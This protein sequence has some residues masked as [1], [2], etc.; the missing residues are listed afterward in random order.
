LIVPLDGNP[1]TNCQELRDILYLFKKTRTVGYSDNQDIPSSWQP[2]IVDEGIGA[3]VH[4]IGTVL[5]SGGVNVDFLL[6]ADFSG[7]ML[8]DGAYT[9]P[10]LSWKIRNYWFG[11]DRTQFRKLELINDSIG[12]HLYC[13]LPNGNLLIGN[14]QNGMNTKDIRWSKWTFDIPITTLELINTTTILLGATVNGVSQ[15]GLYKIVTG[16]TNVTTTVKIPNPLVK[17][18][19]TD[20]GEGENIHHFAGIRLRVKGSGN[21][22]PTVFSL[23][24]VLSEVL[25]PIPMLSTTERQLTRLCNLQTQRAALELKTTELNEIF[26]IG[27]IIFYAKEVFTEFPSVQ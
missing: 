9:R 5:D 15:S 13:V 21:L 26:N 10:E 7:I 16:K 25:V 18:A 23:D 11:L 12:E 20:L 22:K 27:R 8:F 17:T 6:V 4:G 19:Y 3:P 1:L 2:F 24:D 14:Y